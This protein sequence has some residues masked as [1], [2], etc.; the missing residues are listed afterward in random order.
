[1][2]PASING[3]VHNLYWPSSRS[4][5]TKAHFIICCC[6]SSAFTP[7]SISSNNWLSSGT[8]ATRWFVN[9]MIKSYASSTQMPAS[10][11]AFS[12]NGHYVAPA[13]FS[14]PA[15]LMLAITD[16]SLVAF[17]T[18]LCLVNFALFI[19]RWLRKDGD[20]ATPGISMTSISI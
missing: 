8:C 11:A 3:I 5:I 18:F 19:Y 6:S 12:I 20:R 10:L 7:K 13:A 2:V 17:I 15:A 14:I 1:M 16:D 4:L 9:F